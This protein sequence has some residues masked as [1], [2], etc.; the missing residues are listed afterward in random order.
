MEKYRALGCIP[1]GTRKNF[2]SYGSKISEMTQ[3][4]REIL[5][6][7]QTSGGLLVIVKKSGLDD[8]LNLTKASGLMLEAIGKTAAKGEHLVEVK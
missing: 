4:Q 2:A 6:D 3:P 5:C 1:G 7:A 8:F